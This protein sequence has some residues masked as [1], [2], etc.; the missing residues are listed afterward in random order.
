M[1]GFLPERA[2]SGRMDAVYLEDIPG[3]IEFQLSINQFIFDIDGGCRDSA[4]RAAILSTMRRA[5]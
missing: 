2:R 3:A 5:M 4:H 1:S